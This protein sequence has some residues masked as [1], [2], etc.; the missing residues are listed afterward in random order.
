MSLYVIDTDLLPRYQRGHPGLSV[1]VRKMDLGIAAIVLEHN[2]VPATRN[3][4]DFP[5][6]PG[7]LIEDWS[8]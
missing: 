1:N 6:V 8:S 4:R 3:T 7:L 2:G 5:R